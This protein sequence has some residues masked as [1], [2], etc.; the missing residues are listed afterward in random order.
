MKTL[1]L[2]SWSFLLVLLSACN[3][4]EFLNV[5]PQDQ[6]T[7]ESVYQT[8]TDM[9][10]AVNGLYNYLPF[11]EADVSDPKMWFWTD[12]GWRRRGRFG[13]DL[14]WLTNEGETTF[15][16]Y[17]YDGIRQCNEIIARIPDATFETAGLAERLEAEARFIR[18]M[19]Y[20]RMVFV[21]G[22]VA[23]VAEPQGPDFFPA[24]DPRIDV[25][26]FVTAELA[27]IAEVLPASY[28]AVDQGRATKWAALAL[29]ARAN[30]DAIG[31][32]PDPA[33]RYDAAELACEEIINEGDFMLDEGIS[34]FSRL[35]SV[36][37]DFAGSNPSTAVI[38]A[39]VYIEGQ[40]FYEEMSN[41]C[42]PR[43]SYQGFGEGAGNNQAQYAATW[44]CI[45]SFQ[46]INGKAPAEEL[47]TTYFEET[48]FDNMDPR[49]H[50]SFILPGDALQTV[51]G[52]GTIYY[53]W[54]PH[55]DLSIYP[56]DEIPNRTGIETGYLIRKYAGLGVENDSSII[57]D[58]PSRAHADYKIIRYAEILLMMAECKAADNDP[59]AFTYLNRVRERA[60]MPPYNTIADVPLS[61]RSGTT[62]NDLIDAVLLERRYEFAGE[63]FQRWSDIWRYRLGDQVFGLVEGISTDP[64]RPGALEGE[65]YSDVEKVWQDKFYLFPLPQSAIDLNPNIDNNPGW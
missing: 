57:Y 50:A 61:L 1:P 56:Q 29:L 11:L 25:F 54:Q 48:P 51:D 31:W 35:F 43:G 17:R 7:T 3:T 63:G 38:L 23:L 4:D 49:L 6:Y 20:E 46:T 42:L 45:R 64:S 60:G 62:G 47:G 18:A 39:K 26:N 53:N 32:H 44:N 28:G 40:L 9:I 5:V 58:N 14:Q 33:S 30:L 19:L 13:A 16:F 52:G 24:R 8:E 55:P 27:A 12:D 37:S 65:R 34:G 2:I 15:N 59:T 36:E 22:D 21:Y 10:L 41:K